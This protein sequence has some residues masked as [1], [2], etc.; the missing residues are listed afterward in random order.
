LGVLQRLRRAAL[1][2][3]ATA[4]CF[5]AM[6]GS[7]RAAGRANWTPRV[8]WRVTNPGASV[9]PGEVLVNSR[10]VLRLR[11]ELGGL[12]PEQRAQVA[13]DR[14]RAAVASGLTHRDVTV[15]RAT[16]KENPRL[17]ALGQ[18]IAVASSEDTRGTGTT[19]VGL[20]RSWSNALQD[21][22]QVPGVVVIGAEKDKQ[23]IVPLG[24]NRV[25]KIGGAARGAV[26]V[27]LGSGANTV[28][29][30]S[31]DPDAENANVAEVT[32]SG[33]GRGRETLTL[34]REGVQ[35]SVQ[36]AVQPYAGR[37]EPRPQLTIT[38]REVSGERVARYAAFAALNRV[39]PGEG[40][41][42]RLV[43]APNKITVPAVASGQSRTV[44]VPLLLEGQDMIAVAGVAKVGVV[45]R[46]LP[47]AETSDLMYSNNPERLTR[48]G[49]LFA[50]RLNVAN[51]ANRLLYHHQSA[52]DRACVFSVELV[53]DANT[54]ATVQVV[55][56]AAGPVRDTVWVGYRAAAQFVRDQQDDVGAVLELP[57]RSRIAITAPRLLPGLTIS[58]IVQ[59]RQLSGAKPVL[60]RVG[61]DQPEDPRTAPGELLRTADPWT[62]RDAA[63]NSD[64]L[65]L[66]PHVYPGPR[67]VIAARYDVGGRWAFV[68]IGRVPLHAADGGKQRLDGNYGVFYEI[69][70]TLSN[71]TDKPANARL[72]FEPSAGLAG[73]VFLVDGQFVEI[74]Q[75][76]PPAESVLGRYALAPGETRVVRVK[77]LPL[78]GSNYP[79]RLAVQP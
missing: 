72:I 56:G 61:A 20:A 9:P 25:L 27:S 47:P 36:V 24:E 10:I 69:E 64:P 40:A 39:Q 5:V 13:A 71:P 34:V 65:P 44:E 7:S 21:A 73:G 16:N 35:T 14:L 11:S 43:V 23:F 79:I 28:L 4:L 70:F 58:G 78:S 19:P 53:N 30:A 68:S 49:T 76:R 2:W 37:I 15:D 26:S 51:G 59:L 75:I 63:G 17:K 74:P 22:L 1:L 12:L 18:I 42:A 52:L 66:S 46:T 54:P 60:V 38:G 41:T 33:V 6:M 62:N 31:S 55:G 3:T 8:E 32:L 29:R 45:N 50:A 48:F 57:A 77:T 67:K